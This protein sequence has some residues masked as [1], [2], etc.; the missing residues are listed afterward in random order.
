MQ[1]N[2][3]LTAKSVESRGNVTHAELF[4]IMIVEPCIDIRVHSG[5]LID[6]IATICS[7]ELPVPDDDIKVNQAEIN[8]IID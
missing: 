3:V 5:L 2:Q 7:N 6:V 1:W 4:T 8:E